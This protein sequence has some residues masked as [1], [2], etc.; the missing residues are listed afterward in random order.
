MRCLQYWLEYNKSKLLL[1]LFFFLSG[2]M[3]SVVAIFGFIFVF[4]F[5]PPSRVEV[6]FFFWLSERRMFGNERMLCGGV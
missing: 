5:L 4:G 3:G 6:F 1:E 2:L